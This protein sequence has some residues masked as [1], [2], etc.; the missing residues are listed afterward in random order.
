[1]SNNLSVKR[2]ELK[3]FINHLNYVE[4]VSRIQAVLSHVPHSI[5]IC[6]NEMSLIMPSGGLNV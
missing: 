3:Y 4:L 6:L 5:L 1:M 2:S